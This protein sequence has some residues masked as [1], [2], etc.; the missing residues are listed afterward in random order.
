MSQSHFICQSDANC[1]N[2]SDGETSC[3]NPLFVNGL[4]TADETGLSFV[5]LFVRF[6]H[7]SPEIALYVVA[8]SSVVSRCCSVLCVTLSAPQSP[9]ERRWALIQYCDIISFHIL[10]PQHYIYQLP[11]DYKDV[12]A[13][14]VKFSEIVFVPCHV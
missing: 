10:F 5:P 12:G 14:E 7:F 9:T 13:L 8:L 3:F 1:N 6:S 11:P 4:S 2:T